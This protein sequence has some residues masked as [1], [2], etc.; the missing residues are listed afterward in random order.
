MKPKGNE[1]VAGLF[2]L[3]MLFAFLVFLSW[4][5]GGIARWRTARKPAVTWFHSIGGLKEKQQVVY[6]GFPIGEITHIDYDTSRWLIR[7]VMTVDSAFV[8]P[9]RGVAIITAASLLGDP[10]IEITSDFTYLDTRALVRGDERIY[11]KSGYMVIDALDPSSY[12]QLLMQ[13][14]ALVSKVDASF[15]SFADTVG[16]ILTGADLL[17]ANPQ[18]RED[19]HATASNARVA[20]AGLPRT[21]A[22]ADQLMTSANSAA[23]RVDRIIARSEDTVTRIVGNVD[24]VALNARVLTYGLT[25]SPWR[26]VWK[27]P[28]WQQRV[29]GRDPALLRASLKDTAVAPASDAASGSTFNSSSSRTGIGP[30]HA[31]TN[32]NRGQ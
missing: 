18:F 9:D 6:Q 23:G 26:L 31:Y 4:Q 14:S 32:I 7:V 24:E 19:V 16:H 13:G 8:M 28:A 27:D 11:S 3:I 10:Y 21:L 15:T 30:P 20:T 17:V 5:S 1:L 29:N 12:G 25:E 22:N 2:V